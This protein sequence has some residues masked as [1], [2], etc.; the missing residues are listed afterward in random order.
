VSDDPQV[1]FVSDREGRS[2][3]IEIMLNQGYVKE[4]IGKG[5][6]K[7]LKKI[8]EENAHTGMQTFD[9]ALLHLYEEGLITLSD[10]AQAASN[11][12]DFKLLVQQKGHDVSLMTF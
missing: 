11:P 4:L 1:A 7:E 10:A 12:H 8:M 5:E 6:V 9:Q 2:A 3:A